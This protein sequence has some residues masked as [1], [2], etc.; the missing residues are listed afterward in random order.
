MSR[1]LFM[2]QFIAPSLSGIVDAVDRVR[3]QAHTFKRALD[4]TLACADNRY[5]TP[6]IATNDERDMKL[7]YL[8]TLAELCERLES[9]TWDETKA[10]ISPIVWVNRL[11]YHLRQAM[12]VLLP[13]VLYRTVYISSRTS[14]SGSPGSLRVYLFVFIALQSIYDV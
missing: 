4:A 3:K 12:T 13:G 10:V 11:E 14:G 9:G 8:V 6:K 7:C 2:Q 5:T 1:K